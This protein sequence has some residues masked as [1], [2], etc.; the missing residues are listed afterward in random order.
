MA[1]GVLS[2]IPGLAGYLGGQA[3]D[4]QMQ[5]GQLQQMG[6]LQG[7]LSKQQAMQEQQHIKG[8]LSRVVQETGGDPVKMGPLLLQTGNPKLMELG[9]RMM[10]KPAEPKLVNTVAADGTTPIQRFVTPA[11]GDIYPTAPKE[12]KPQE[13]WGEPFQLGGATVQ[14]SSTGQIKTAVTREPRVSVTAPPPVSTIVVKDPSSSTGWSYKDA[15]TGRV[16]S[17]DAP[18]PAADPGRAYAGATARESG[19]DDV[20]QYN[21][22]LSA[23]N[24][25]PKIKALVKHI[26]SSDALTGLGANIRNNIE[27]AKVLLANDK[28]AGKV[29]SDTE[30]LDALMGSEVFSMIKPL[31][32][33]AR[34]LDTPSEREFLRK[35]LTGD[36][37][38]NKDTLRRMALL[39]QDITE[40]AIE[41]WNKRVRS[42]DLDA[43][44]TA[45]GRKKTEFPSSLSSTPETVVP[46]EPKPAGSGK[47]SI[48]PL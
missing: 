5:M 1:D 46:E 18:A 27:R 20:E 44:F 47:W 12:T 7:I 16:T 38:L 26:E 19:K 4:Q 39:R 3:N 8:V 35:V 33:G 25:I 10:P 45:T 15:R 11:A 48:K 29:V 22:A 32:I 14:K 42:G 6:A 34:G 17:Q 2:R 28:K 9:H 36:I 23:S 43:F 40:R 13:T 24:D 31:G 21:T 41:R 30:Y 37:S